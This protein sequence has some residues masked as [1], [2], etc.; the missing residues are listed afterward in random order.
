MRSERTT[1]RVT[2]ELLCVKNIQNDMINTAMTFF[3]GKSDYYAHS[4]QSGLV[5]SKVS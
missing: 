3:G 1:L 2:C 5:V 4:I